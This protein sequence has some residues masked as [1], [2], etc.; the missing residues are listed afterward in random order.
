MFVNGDKVVLSKEY[1]FEYHNG[2]D[3]YIP[4]V[5]A[6][7]AKGNPPVTIIKKGNE[8]NGYYVTGGLEGTWADDCFELAVQI[9][10]D[11]SLFE[12]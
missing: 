5:I 11:D 10:L 7:I 3:S 6:H 4:S 12:L 2:D 9:K 1:L 8:F